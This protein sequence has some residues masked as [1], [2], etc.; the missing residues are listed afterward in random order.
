MQQALR[1]ID[2]YQLAYARSD[3]EPVQAR[4]RKRKLLR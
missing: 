2:H 3:F 1:D 4:L